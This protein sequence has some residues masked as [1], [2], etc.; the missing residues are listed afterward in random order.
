MQPTIGLL[1]RVLAN[2]G[3]VSGPVVATIQ[4]QGIEPLVAIGRPQLRWPYDF[5]PP[6]KP[7]P[8]RVLKEPWRIAMKDK[9][10]TDDAKR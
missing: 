6:F 10:E 4:A 2:T 9:L 8:T 3:Y 1:Q 7:K 5:R